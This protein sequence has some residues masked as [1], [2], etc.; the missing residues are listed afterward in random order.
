MTPDRDITTLLQAARQGDK[1]ALDQVWTILSDDLHKNARGQLANESPACERG[2]TSLLHDA[3]VRL[4]GHGKI[5]FEN[6][7]EFFAAASRV[8]QQ[9]LVDDARKRNRQ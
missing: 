6:R 5:D 1:Q 9:I 4:A 8:M 2:S 7:R 3:Y